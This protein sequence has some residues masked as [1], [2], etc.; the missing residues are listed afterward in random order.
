MLVFYFDRSFSGGVWKQLYWLLLIS[1]IVVVALLAISLLML[2]I[3]NDNF[4]S[5]FGNR[6]FNLLCV[7]TGKGSINSID[8]TWKWMSLLI[9]II[10]TVL[11]SSSLISV[12]SNMLARRIERFKEGQTSYAFKNHIIII[13]YDD[14]VP[15]L[16]NQLLSDKKNTKA[17]IVVMSNQ[18]AKH[19]SNSIQIGIDEEYYKRVIVLNGSSSSVE[20]LKKLNSYKATGLYLLGE[21][22]EQDRDSLN[23]DCLKKIVSIHKAQKKIPVIPVHVFFEHQTTFSAFQVTDIASEW[24]T[25]IDFKPINFCE[26]WAKRILVSRKYQNA[27]EQIVYPFLDRTPIT[28]NSDETVHILIVGMTNMGFAIAKEA[29]QTIHFP[30][31]CKN[32]SKKTKITFLDD[33]A[34]SLKNVFITRYKHFFELTGFY[35]KNMKGN[36]LVS[37]YYSP[38]ETETNNEFIDI[39][40][41]FI[42][43]NTTDSLVQ[44]AINE[45]SKA[46]EHFTIIICMDNSAINM[47]TGLFLPNCVYDNDIPILIK[48]DVSGSLLTLLNSKS[49]EE[50][51]H[52]YS[53]LFPFGMKDGGYDHNEKYVYLAQCIHYIYE[54]YNNNKDIPSSIIDKSELKKRW[55]E[56]PVATQW[57]N[58]YAAYTIESKI[59]IYNHSSDTNDNLSELMS[60]VEH[61]R[62]NCEKL[63]LGF[64]TPNDDERVFM[65]LDNAN[66]KLYKQ[67]YYIHLD[68]RPYKDLKED[69]KNYDRCMIKAIP[70][71]E[72]ELTKL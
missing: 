42:K 6:L 39:C 71:L 8:P 3:D 4:E 57:S 35:Y 69:I 65:E 20:D 17:Y 5:Q 40:F 54:Y 26:E 32:A 25:Y 19:V 46:K 28:V 34:D 70:L 43:G 33:N 64:R 9:A 72:K 60:E 24:R 1:I 27:T 23:V 37:N 47:E 68:I 16:I 58:L 48:Q 62:W 18:P 49:F 29:A 51:K 13:G 45:W 44:E 52:K 41:E 61:N 53:H 30:N 36:E 56:L 14:R 38:I 67:K 11:F 22:N 10:G 31:F 2:P 55:I 63:L 59:R 12:I 7:F 66:A 50:S 15:S 21:K